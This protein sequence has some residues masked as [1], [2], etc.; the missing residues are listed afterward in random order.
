VS[1]LAGSGNRIMSWDG[2]AAQAMFLT[3]TGLAWDAARPTVLYVADDTAVRAVRAASRWLQAL[4]AVSETPAAKVSLPDGRVT[5]VAG[6][7]VPG[8]VDAAGTSAK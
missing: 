3:P 6:G 2:V 4:G 1:T 7:G 5:T 8:W